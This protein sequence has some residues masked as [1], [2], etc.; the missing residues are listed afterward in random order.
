MG[1]P[2]HS[3]TEVDDH[4]DL[5]DNDYDVLDEWTTSSDTLLSENDFDMI[6]RLSAALDQVTH[7][8][9][10]K[11]RELV[12]KSSAWTNKTRDR[13]RQQ[14]KK[15]ETRRTLLEQKLVK[16]YESIN[17]RMNKD[18]K[19]VQLRD[20][21]SFVVGVGNACITPALTARVPQWIPL[22]YTIQSLYLL[23]LRFVVYKYRRWHYFIFD[24]CYFV[25]V[26]VLFY[27][28]VFPGSTYLFYATYTLTSGPV[29]WAIVTWRNSLVFHSLDK[30]TS[31]F[32]HIFPALVTYVIRWLPE[33]HP[34]TPAGTLY[35]DQHFPALKA[36]LS[37]NIV[38]SF[39]DCMVSSTMAYLIWQALY[40]VF[41]MVK[42]REKVESGL[43]VTS[44]SWLLNDS[45]STHKKSFIQRAAFIFGP[46]YKA[47]MFMLLQLIYNLVTTV[48]TYFM[49]KHFWLH[50]L[51][52]CTMFG[53]SVWNGANYYIEV[54][55]RRYLMEIEQGIVKR[56]VVDQDQNKTN[57]ENRKT[58]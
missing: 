18:A 46:Q 40:F 38:M 28:W 34:D 7:Q 21:V 29:A 12:Q 30:V 39:K 52:L 4:D 3:P 49:F 32:I 45:G 44:Y 26:L 41:I 37:G 57:V 35:R 2:E 22:Y 5:F 58:T 36:S 54:F 25:N 43:R 53:A 15:L 33:L 23:S 20:K 11:Q 19:T 1:S 16:Q 56:N 50:T 31:V 51:F 55:S 27:L 13:I 8:L 10:D 14:T 9:N 42:R 6:D 24:L 47:Y 48:P 17:A